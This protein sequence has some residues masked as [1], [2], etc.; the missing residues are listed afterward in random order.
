MSEYDVGQIV[1]LLPWDVLVTTYELDS[2]GDIEGPNLT[3]VTESAYSKLK[4]YSNLVFTV[5]YSGNTSIQSN[6]PDDFN[7]WL[8]FPKW[9]VDS[10]FKVPLL[11]R[12]NE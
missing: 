1:R 6:C 7:N 11:R 9:A 12:R 3:N 4:A 10:N 5:Q 2:D 8:W